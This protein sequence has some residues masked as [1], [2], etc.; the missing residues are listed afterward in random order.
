MNDAMK[1]FMKRMGWVLL[2]V[3]SIRC[4]WSW[5][6]LSSNFSI[7]SLFG[8][9]GEAIGITTFIAILYEKLLWRYDR[10]LDWPVLYKKY[11]GIIKSNY[12]SKDREI[13]LTVKQ[14]LFSVFVFLTTKESRSKAITADII[15]RDGEYILCYSYL[16]RPKVEIRER[17]EIHYGTSI[18]SIG[19]KSQ[20]LE[21][22]YYTDRNTAGDIC[23]RK[24][25]EV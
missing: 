12:D 16:N 22:E 5:R 25:D 21:G 11:E 10:T 15:N 4:G 20:T 14:S 7:Y 19:E 13:T 2:I 23:L 24:T 17:S 18:L 6:E 3:F 1:T 8:Y 9:A